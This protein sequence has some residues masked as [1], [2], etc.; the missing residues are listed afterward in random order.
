MQGRA[1]ITG[2]VTAQ[3][4]SRQV[5]TPP[6]APPALSAGSRKGGAAGEVSVPS[7]LADYRLTCYVTLGRSRLLSELQLL[8]WQM[9]SLD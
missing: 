1:E 8:H 7:T 6:S 5:S 4:G 3:D 9:K 2:R